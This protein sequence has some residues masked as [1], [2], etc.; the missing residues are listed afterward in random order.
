[1]RLAEAPTGDAADSIGNDLAEPHDNWLWN[2]IARL[3]PSRATQGQVPRA[4][5]L[6]Y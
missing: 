1:M 2:T 5:T 3:C 4:I 6:A